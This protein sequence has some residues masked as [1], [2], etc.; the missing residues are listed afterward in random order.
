MKGIEEHN[1]SHFPISQNKLIL[2][3]QQRAWTSAH[4]NL[5]F[6]HKKKK[7]KLHVFKMTILQD[8]NEF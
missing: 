6:I 7:T 1:I 3:S 4:H 8:V 2:V 5:F